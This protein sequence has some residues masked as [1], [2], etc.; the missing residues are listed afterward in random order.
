MGDHQQQGTDSLNLP[1]GFRFHP[2]DEEIITFYLTPKVLQRGFTCAAIGEVDLNKTEPWDLPEKAKMMGQKEWYFFCQ[3]DRKYPT[4]MRANRATEGGYWKAT[5]K[6]K[7]IYRAMPGVGM[8]P[9]L[10]GMKKTLVFY[11][12]RAPRGDKTSWVM[13]EYRLEGSDGLPGPTSNSTSSGATMTST[14]K[15]VVC[16]VFHKTSGVKKAH[17]PLSYPVEMGATGGD[18]DQTSIPLSMPMQFPI[19]PDFTLDPLASFYS[20]VDASSSLVP[21]LMPPMAGMGSTELQV[22]NAMF[23]NLMASPP[24]PMPFVNHMDMGVAGAGGFMA[25]PESRPSSLV[26]HKD[27]RMSPDQTYTIEIPSMVST[28]PAPA[29]TMDMNGM[30]KH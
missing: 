18:M 12:G 25:A 2:R 15:W 19:L 9:L 27:T 10:V 30:W 7:E 22:N 28:I 17:A 13:H 5:G 21:P 23:R 16:R 29:A 4:G 24:L 1:P 8:M 20:T 6:D 11:K 14:S 26:S 3:K